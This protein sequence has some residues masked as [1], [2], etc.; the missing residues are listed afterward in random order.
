MRAHIREDELGR[1]FE[2]LD[3]CTLGS[4]EL[5]KILNTSTRTIRNWRSG[6]YT[7]P[8]DKLNTI[9]RI[10]GLEKNDISL[11]VKDEWW[12][13]KSAGK[14]GGASYIEK[15]GSIGT[16]DSKRLG[17]VS[18]YNRRRQNP[19]DIYARK[20]I[21]QPER[22]NLLAEFVGILIGDGTV[23][24]Y[25]VSVS[26]N[27]V[28]DKKYAMVIKDMFYELFLI[29]AKISKLKNSNCLT[30]TASSVQLVNYM[31]GQGILM[32]D[33]ISQGLDI[34][35]WILGNRSL[36][37]ACVRGIFDTDGCVYNER[38]TVR[39]RTYSYPRLSIVSA[40]PY[41]RESIN[42]VLKSLD[43]CPTIRNN[44][45]VNLEKRRDIDRYFSIVGSSNPKHIDRYSRYG[46]VG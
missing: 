45:S 14:R 1:I 12:G 26:V 11:E 6:K 43:L 38:H 7:I 8:L 30:I 20:T 16:I 9:L 23:S 4:G 27:S 17:G 25:Q 36:S 22:T 15:Y 31:V 5:A 3:K 28:D 40:S 39:G 37:I 13:N 18:S 44:R 24:K 41:L 21:K 46:G 42:S 33:K 34:P 2:S 10:S 19:N 32:G 29:D 35:P